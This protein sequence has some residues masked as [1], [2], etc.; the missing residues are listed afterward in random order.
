MNKLEFHNQVRMVFP[1][2]YRRA[3]TKTDDILCYIGD[4]FS[5][6]FSN[7]NEGVR[8]TGG[9][10][11]GPDTYSATIAYIIDLQKNEARKN[12]LIA[13]KTAIQWKKKIGLG[14]STETMKALKAL[15]KYVKTGEMT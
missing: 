11:T 9:P 10:T 7:T 13:T 14:N 8:V 6:K 15:A 3:Q 4:V 2:F 1:D 12:L 5:L